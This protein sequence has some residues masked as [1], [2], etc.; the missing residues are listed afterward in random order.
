M[1]SIPPHSTDCT[2][3]ARAIGYDQ[4]K[5]VIVQDGRVISHRNVE[6]FRFCVLWT[7]IGEKKQYEVEE[8][9]ASGRLIATISGFGRNA[10]T[11]DTAAASRATANRWLREMRTKHPA[12]FFRV[13][14]QFT[15]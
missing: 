10:G 9:D 11:L 13:K 12:R 2:A 6:W 3:Y 4:D 15:T 7:A 1:N 5:P 8:I 14:P